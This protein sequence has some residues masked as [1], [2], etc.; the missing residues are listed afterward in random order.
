MTPLLPI[1]I[2]TA[3]AVWWFRPIAREQRRMTK[4]QYELFFA[5]ENVEFDPKKVGAGAAEFNRLGF[6]ASSKVLADRAK[7]LAKQ[8]RGLV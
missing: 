2:G 3:A 8:M 1:L 4:K 7:R 6:P 5:L